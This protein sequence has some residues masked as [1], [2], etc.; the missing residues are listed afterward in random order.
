MLE[1]LT[2]SMEL[3]GENAYWMERVIEAGK[4]VG[5]VIPENTSVSKTKCVCARLWK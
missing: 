3:A 1:E 4:V 5:Q 2:E